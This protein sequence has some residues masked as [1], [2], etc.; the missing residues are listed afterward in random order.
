LNWAGRVN[1]WLHDLFAYTKS[2]DRDS[3]TTS[4]KTA[5]VTKTRSF[6]GCR[7]RTSLHIG[8]VQITSPIPPKRQR[9]TPLF[10]CRVHCKMSHK[11]KG[12]HPRARSLK[13]KNRRHH[14]LSAECSEAGKIDTAASRKL[15]VANLRNT[16][17]S[18][19]H[20]SSSLD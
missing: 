1:G 13:R 18:L 12:I 20:V 2:I 19:A 14:G 11:V 15:S 9:R 7:R 6:P 10:R 8:N 3:I 16:I 4:R 5:E 17:I